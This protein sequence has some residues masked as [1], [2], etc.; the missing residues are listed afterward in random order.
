M[1]EYIN[2]VLRSTGTLW[3]T[4]IKFENVM[5]CENMLDNIK[6]RMRSP[7]NYTHTPYIVIL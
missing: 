2:W 6:Y 7:S 4:K 1:A 3:E 5:M